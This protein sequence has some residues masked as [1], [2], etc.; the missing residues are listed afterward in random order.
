MSLKIFGFVF[1]RGKSKGLKNKNLLKINNISLIGHS[2]LQVKKIKIITDV[3]V[4]TDS[5][6]I[7]KEAVKYGAKVPFIRPKRL[8]NDSSPEILAWRHSV[9]FLKSKLNLIPDYIVSVPTTSPLRGASD[10]RRCLNLAIKKKL[11]MVFT[12]SKSSKNPYFNMVKLKKNNIKILIKPSKILRRR[13][14]APQCFD[15]STVCYVFKP[16]YI[17]KNDDLLSGKI[18]YVLIPKE[19][20]VD[21]DDKWDYQICK[22]LYKKVI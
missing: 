7:K 5:K 8:S 14:D 12:I 22:A 13:Q 2:I 20:A 15:I 4:S 11:D 1:A 19:R 6:K 21:I 16:D 17:I 10:I 3:F 9:N 18:G